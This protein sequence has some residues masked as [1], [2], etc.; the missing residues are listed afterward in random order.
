[1][2]RVNRRTAL[3]GAR[4]RMLDMRFCRHNPLLDIKPAQGRQSPMVTHMQLQVR[5]APSSL[6]LHPL[7]NSQ[8]AISPLSWCT[9]RLTLWSQHGKQI[10]RR[11]QGTQ[12]WDIR[13]VKELSLSHQSVERA[14]TLAR[15]TGKLDWPHAT[16]SIQLPLTLP[17]SD[18]PEH[19]KAGKEP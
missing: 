16:F 4:P 17:G 15:G 18:A 1:M 19:A 3:L 10:T 7:Y 8:H 11:L 6:S 14:R 2:H 13:W 12:S 9:P 5:A